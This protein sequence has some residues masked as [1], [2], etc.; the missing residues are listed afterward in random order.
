MPHVVLLTGLPATGKF[1]VGTEM[2]RQM[3]DR[4]MPARLVDNHYW[5]NV[6][7]ALLGNDGNGQTLPPEVWQRIME[8]GEAI[9]RTMEDLSPPERHGSR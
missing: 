2:V 6:I 7:F 4:G 5:N 8:V 3:E 1:T 9:Y